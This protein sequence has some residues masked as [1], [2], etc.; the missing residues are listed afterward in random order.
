MDDLLS[1]IE[2]SGQHVINFDDLSTF[3][4]SFTRELS[5]YLSSLKS[6]ADKNRVDQFFM[7][8]YKVFQIKQQTE[9]QYEQVIYQQGLDALKLELM[10]IQIIYDSMPKHQKEFINQFVPNGEFSKMIVAQRDNIK[11]RIIGDATPEEKDLDLNWMGT[12]QEVELPQTEGTD[13]KKNIVP[14]LINQKFM[15]NDNYFQYSDWE[16]EMKETFDSFNLLDVPRKDNDYKYFYDRAN[17]QRIVPQ[18]IFPN[19]N[20]KRVIL[21]PQISNTTKEINDQA[22]A[23]YDTLNQ[24]ERDPLKM[25][26]HKELQRSADLQDLQDDTSFITNLTNIKQ[27]L[28]NDYSDKQILDLIL[29][30]SNFTEAMI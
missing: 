11:M 2:G 4:A 29:V 20:H 27:G 19:P 6:Q 28:K 8:L 14:E 24:F 16:K 9:K 3:G 1:Q 22:Q 13:L 12:R 10:R 18:G 30:N 5:L 15:W 7:Q 25:L 26:V 17:N 23:G 21:Q